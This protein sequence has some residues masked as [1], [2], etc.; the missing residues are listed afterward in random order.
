MKHSHQNK[1]QTNNTL[2]KW[3]VDYTSTSMKTS[4][5][6]SVLCTANLFHLIRQ[7]PWPVSVAVTHRELLLQCSVA[8]APQRSPQRGSHS[9]QTAVL[10]HIGS[11]AE[12]PCQQR[13]SVPISREAALHFDHFVCSTLL[14]PAL[15]TSC[16]RSLNRDLVAVI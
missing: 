11:Q 13:D 1:T 5:F 16:C 3:L 14:G 10:G 12:A 8:P 6:S 15:C 9:E 2:R 7:N 4:R